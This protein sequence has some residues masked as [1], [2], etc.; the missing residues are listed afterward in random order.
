M[1]VAVALDVLEKTNDLTPDGKNMV[2]TVFA[3]TSQLAPT[4]LNLYVQSEVQRYRMAAFVAVLIV[5]LPLLAVV[6]EMVEG[7]KPLVAGMME[8]VPA[9]EMAAIA[10]SAAIAAKMIIFFIVFSLR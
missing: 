7:L 10:I 5:V 1:L 2:S 6:T 4:P 9:K 8:L 3:F